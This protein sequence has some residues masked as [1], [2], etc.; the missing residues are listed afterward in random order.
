MRRPMLLALSLVGLLVVGCGGNAPSDSGGGALQV[1]AAEN[2]WGSLAAQ[3]GGEHVHVTSI[4]TSPDADPHDYEPRAAD[5]R[6]MAGAR[7]AIVNGIGYDEWASRLITANPVGDRVVLNVGDLVGLAPGGNPHQWYAPDTVQRVIDRIV[8]DYKLVDAKD[9]G[10]FERRRRLV[11]SRNLGR[12]RALIAQI[13]A[14][15][16]GTPVGASES[17][18]A[19]LATALRLRLLT[20]AAF[21]NAI[22]EGTDPT[23]ADKQ[24]AD[25]QITLKQI[26]VWVY[27]RQNTTPDVKRLND[28]ARQAGIPVTTVTETLTPAGASFQGWQV[29]QLEELSRALGAATGR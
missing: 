5:A 26:K 9:A 1:V 20:P 14:R 12:Y 16:G 8:A 28:A 24:A 29:R 19:P 7:L 3:L 18:F 4:I 15:Y 22:S 11:E 21:L 13:R 2:F 17:I 27:N 25:R 10:Y 6:T 23:A